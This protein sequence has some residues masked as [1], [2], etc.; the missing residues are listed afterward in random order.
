MTEPNDIS[1]I[2]RQNGQSLE[3]STDNEPSY[4]AYVV[5]AWFTGM[6]VAYYISF[7]PLCQQEFLDP[8]EPI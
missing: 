5:P 8:Y 2:R 1:D 7:Q 3:L 6:S 4:I